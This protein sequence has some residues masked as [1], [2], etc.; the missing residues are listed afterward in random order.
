MILI[1]NAINR[2]RASLLKYSL[3]RSD[4]R[5]ALVIVLIDYMS[6]QWSQS[7]K[8]A[9]LFKTAIIIVSTETL[10]AQQLFLNVASNFFSNGDA[11]LQNSY[12]ITFNVRY[13]QNIL[14]N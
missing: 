10:S 1:T 8:I 4:I 7:F 9:N 13:K 14:Y 6:L 5:F 11:F 12:G 3:L 2:A